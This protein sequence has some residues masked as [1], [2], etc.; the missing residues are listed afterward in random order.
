AA[1]GAMIEPVHAACPGRPWTGSRDGGRLPRGGGGGGAGG[2]VGGGAQVVMTVPRLPAYACWPGTAGSTPAA[3]TAP[4]RPP[5]HPTRQPP[6][7]ERTRGR[8]RSVRPTR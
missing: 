7:G 6:T 1:A 8:P 2:L 5:R 4:G 3:A